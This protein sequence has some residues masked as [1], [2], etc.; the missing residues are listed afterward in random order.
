MVNTPAGFRVDVTRSLSNPQG[1]QWSGRALNYTVPCPTSIQ[2]SVQ[3]CWT[4]QAL[5]RLHSNIDCCH[6]VWQT[7][8]F[9]KDHIKTVFWGLTAGSGTFS[10]WDIIFISNILDLIN[11]I[12]AFP[13]CVC[14]AKTQHAIYW[15]FGNFLVLFFHNQLNAFKIY[16]SSVLTSGK[17]HAS[18][19]T[20][21]R[22]IR[23]KYYLF[24][25]REPVCRPIL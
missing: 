19:I 21:W 13:V 6:V 3:K 5:H 16:M 10:C 14:V 24:R 20:L 12:H 22:V 18:K 1:S 8:L 25:G 11:N 23:R 15:S 17:V 2:L 4:C 7:F 9:S